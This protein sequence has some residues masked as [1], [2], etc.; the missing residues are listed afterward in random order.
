MSS[1]AFHTPEADLYEDRS[2]AVPPIAETL[3]PT[4]GRDA[5]TAGAAFRNAAAAHLQTWSTKEGTKITSRY[6]SKRIN[7]KFIY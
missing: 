5:E 6:S 7:H 2:G 1:I 4:L 3:A